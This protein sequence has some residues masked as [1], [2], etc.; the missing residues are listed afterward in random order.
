MTS[1][2]YKSRL[3]DIKHFLGRKA[4]LTMLAGTIPKRHFQPPTNPSGEM[5][6]MIRLLMLFTLQYQSA[7]VTTAK[8]LESLLG[9]KP[10]S[11]DLKM[12]KSQFS[13]LQ[14]NFRQETEKG[15][16]LF[17]RL[18]FWSNCSC[19]SYAGN[20]SVNIELAQNPFCSSQKK[21]TDRREER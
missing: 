5:C 8:R 14:T 15:N 17:T 4:S 2:C 18:L 6:A 12:E 10:T 1:K 20:F 21:A 11:E 19:A 16:F 13:V 7:S 9:K 3:A